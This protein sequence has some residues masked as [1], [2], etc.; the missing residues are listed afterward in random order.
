M[1]EM[2]GDAPTGKLLEN[3]TEVE[4]KDPTVIDKEWATD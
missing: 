4:D 2:F 1:T 3:G